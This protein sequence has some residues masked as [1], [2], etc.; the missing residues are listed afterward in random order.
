[1]SSQRPFEI[2]RWDSANLPTVEMMT[3]WMQREGMA[4]EQTEHAVGSQTE[5]LK[6]P[7]PM[8]R[9]LISGHLQCTF[10]GYGVVELKS[11]DSVEIQPHTLHDLKVISHEPV[12]LLSALRD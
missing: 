11:G 2:T 7:H 4:P 12:L 6:Y 10:P 3:K 8:V 9:T 5:E 1:M